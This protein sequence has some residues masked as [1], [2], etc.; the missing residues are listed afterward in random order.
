MSIILAAMFTVY[1]SIVT[2]NYKILGEKSSYSDS[3]LN[4]AGTTGCVVNCISRIF[5]GNLFEKYSLRRIATV[6]LS[7]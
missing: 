2:N 3:F 4:A 7:F 1:G 5:W 6:N